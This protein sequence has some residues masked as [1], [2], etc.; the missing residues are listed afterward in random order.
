MLLQISY[1]IVA[2]SRA[3]NGPTHTSCQSIHSYTVL[4]TQAVKY[5]PHMLVYLAT[6]KTYKASTRI[7]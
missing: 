2:R 3:I 7:T 1:H 4:L 6:G 5:P